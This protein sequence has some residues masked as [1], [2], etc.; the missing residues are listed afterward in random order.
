VCNRKF[1]GRPDIE[2]RFTAGGE[3]G[4]KFLCAD[5]RR[6]LIRFFQRRLKHA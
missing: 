2:Y 1:F 5:F 3:N 6:P 4:L